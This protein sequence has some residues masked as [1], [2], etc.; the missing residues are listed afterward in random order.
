MSR[1]DVEKA[2]AGCVKSLGGI[3]LDETLHQPKFLNA[4]YWFPAH[5]V[6]A[7]LKCLTED[8]WSRESFNRS[9]SM[10]YES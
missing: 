6:I 9:L 3:V 2:F 1:I 8:Y 10:L 5:N 7:E 4:D